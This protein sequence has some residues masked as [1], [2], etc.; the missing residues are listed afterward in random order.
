[1]R[2]GVFAWFSGEGRSAGHGEGENNCGQGC[3]ESLWKQFYVPKLCLSVALARHA[4]AGCA[5]K[6]VKAPT[7]PGCDNTHLHKYTGGDRHTPKRQH[8]LD[9]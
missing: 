9:N 3:G 5:S 4:C 8:G 6:H 7:A 2:A 1:M